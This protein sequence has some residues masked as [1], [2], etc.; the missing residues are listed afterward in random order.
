M[1]QVR[2]STVLMEAM[3]HAVFQAVSRCLPIAAARI[4]VRAACGVCGGQSDTGASFLRVLGFPLPIIPPIS[5]SS[6]STA[7]KIGL[8]VA[9][10]PSGRNWTP[11]PNIPILKKMYG[12]HVL[13]GMTVLGA[14]ETLYFVQCAEQCSY[15]TAQR[16]I[17]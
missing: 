17:D 5:P 15:V 3:G 14:T 9:A 12:S 8:L 16:L 2:G 6:S 7:G 11:P 10:V 13:P 4:R 1:T